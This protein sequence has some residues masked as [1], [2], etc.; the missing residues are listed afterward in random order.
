MSSII[1]FVKSDITGLWQL[2]VSGINNHAEVKSRESLQDEDCHTRVHQLTLTV[3]IK[4]KCLP[5]L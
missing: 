1:C 5:V 3:Q 4:M 2:D